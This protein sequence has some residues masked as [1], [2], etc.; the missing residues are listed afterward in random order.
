M[1]ASRSASKAI[2]HFDLGDGDWVDLRVL[3][4]SDRQAVKAAMVDPDTE[5]ISKERIEQGNVVALLRS[6]SAWG[7]P[8]FGCTCEAGCKCGAE[9]KAPFHAAD[10]HVMAINEEEVA[11]LDTTGD[12]LLR[13][14]DAK[15][16]RARHGGDPFLLRPATSPSSEGAGAAD[17]LPPT[18]TS[19]PSSASGTS[20][21][22]PR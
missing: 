9:G 22:E 16:D 2:E 12:V 6:I 3:N 4:F 17:R 1:T 19:G 7:G 10:C 18:S 11:G 20:T 15:A 8:G 5:T 14:V 13:L 21:P